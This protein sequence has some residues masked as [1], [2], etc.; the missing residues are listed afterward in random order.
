MHRTHTRRRETSKQSHTQ[1]QRHKR[2][3]RSKSGSVSVSVH[4]TQN[5]SSKS[6]STSFAHIKKQMDDLYSLTAVDPAC[7]NVVL[8]MS[9]TDRTA[10]VNSLVHAVGKD[11]NNK[12]D[13]IPDTTFDQLKEA[14]LVLGK[15]SSL[16]PTALVHTYYYR[17]VTLSSVRVKGKTHYPFLNNFANRCDRG[18]ELLLPSELSKSRTLRY[19]HVM[20]PPQEVIA[21][22]NKLGL[23]H[24]SNVDMLFNYLDA[25]TCTSVD[26][27]HVQ[28]G[29]ICNT[30]TQLEQLQVVMN[31]S[32][33]G[34]YDEYD[35]LNQQFE[36]MSLGGFEKRH[37]VVRRQL[38]LKQLM[39]AYM[40]QTGATF[41]TIL[42]D[43]DLVSRTYQLFTIH[44][45]WLLN[46]VFKK[47]TLYRL[48]M[49]PYEGHVRIRCEG[50]LVLPAKGWDA[51]RRFYVSHTALFK[52]SQDSPEVE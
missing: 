38:F 48:P 49:N 13:A 20:K 39:I 28:Q 19:R 4:R 7:T 37:L 45:L 11:A 1:G 32:S 3:R 43:G 16:W 51:I 35:A 47:V 8:H 5:A 18:T 40:T 17:A 33:T 30:N 24:V 10:L 31:R 34:L 52:R 27:N 46:I 44:M 15:W 41:H 2:G 14:R 12:E 42:K 9:P 50:R 6:T 36:I 21:Y 23:P 22:R 26:I 29:F 25:D